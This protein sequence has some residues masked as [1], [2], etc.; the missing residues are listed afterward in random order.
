MGDTV[1]GRDRHTIAAMPEAKKPG[2][3]VIHIVHFDTVVQLVSSLDF[4]VSI[5][6]SVLPVIDRDR[7]STTPIGWFPTYDSMLLIM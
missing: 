6:V 1:R 5:L 3:Q 4:C 2:K 7:L